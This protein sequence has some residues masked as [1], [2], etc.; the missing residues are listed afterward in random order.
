MD[1]LK[2]GYSRLFALLAACILAVGIAGCDGDDGNRGAAGT[3]GADG[4][5][6]LACWDLN[7]NG[8]GDIPDEDTNGD[9]V[10]D[11]DDCRAVGD[12]IEIGT[13]DELT[14]EQIEE[15]GGLVADIVDVQVASPPVVT[16][17]V[18]DAH[19]NPALGIGQGVVWFTFVKLI[20][21]AN[22]LPAYWQSYVNRVETANANPTPNV[23][24]QSVQATTDSAGTLVELGGGMYEYTF[25]TD[26]ANVT[27]P[28][29]V[30]WEP[31]LPHRVGLEIRLDDAAEPLAPDNPVYDFIPDTGEVLDPG[32]NLIADTANCTECHYRFDLHG[33]PRRT[34]EYCVTCHNPGTIDQDTGDSVDMKYLAHSIHPGLNRGDLECSPGEDDPNDPDFCENQYPY[35][36]YGYGDNVHDY[37]E[38]TYPQD[39]L[40]CENCHEASAA[41]PEGD[42]W[43]TVAN[44]TSC[45]G[46]H[47][48]GLLA[49][50]PDAVTG[51]PTYQFDHGAAGADGGFAVVA[52]EGSCATCHLGSIQGAGPALAIHSNIRGSDR[53]RAESGANFVYEFLSATNTGPGETPVVTFRITDPAGVP[54]N[55]LTDAE[56]TDANAALN[57]YVQW[58]TDAYYGGDENGLVLGARQNDD[59]TIQAVQDLNFRDTGYPYRMRIGAIQDVAVDNG[60]GSFTVTFFRA[61]PTAFTGDVAFALGG[62]PAWDYTDADGVTEFGPGRTTSAV[63]FPGAPREVGFDSAN[64]NACHKQLQA[65]GGNRNGNYEMCL[66]CHNGDA[67]VCSANP[68]VDGSCP[69]GETQEG[70]GMG[71]MVH[72]IHIASE[73][74]DGGRFAEVTYP[75]SVTNCEACH[76]PGGYN[77]ARP[78]A[79]S[80]STNQGSD[81]RVWTDDI[82]TTATSTAC[83]V[84]HSDNAAAGHFASN[85]GQ[86]GVPK[87]TIV[88]ADATG[89][90]PNGQEACL[91][92]HG[93]GATFD[94]TLYHH[95]GH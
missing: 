64:C 74:Y 9:G 63:F 20:P 72:S 94:T 84:C 29:A 42:L 78:D 49:S 90:I 57:L 4:A 53:R 88:G 36:I 14:E 17:M 26:V 87:D 82:A 76:T 24:P 38:V 79:R 71:L 6:G 35:I 7:G 62:H 54:Y 93:A 75:Q 37:S 41:T 45:G 27:D 65:H 46:C 3:D 48:N 73:T 86:V 91:V 67:A 22:G 85:G 80:V 56:F 23:L 52:E 50:N 39:I 95:A 43:N 51:V 1:A 28:I 92:C 61:L 55:I 70:Y 81:I 34:V 25:A 40:Y 2:N 32:V 59:L 19:G 21:A 44:A 47:A 11:V 8:V 69:P 13:G 15:L 83:G 33:G 77:A 89:G 18:E 31:T 5:D 60:D 16:F 66:V 30:A 58:S 10:V 68:E 12:T